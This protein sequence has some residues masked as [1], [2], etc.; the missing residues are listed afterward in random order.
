[1]RDLIIKLKYKPG[2]SVYVYTKDGLALKK[3]D[4]IVAWVEDKTEVRYYIGS[5]DYDESQILPPIYKDAKKRL[6]SN[7]NQLQLLLD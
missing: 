5:Q 7:A 1:M 2:D 4:R 6:E 3:I